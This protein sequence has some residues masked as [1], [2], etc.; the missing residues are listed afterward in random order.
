MVADYESMIAPE[1][2]YAV[3]L[4]KKGDLRW[5]SSD[6]ERKTQPARGF[7]QR[8]TDFFWRLIPVEGQL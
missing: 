4:N 1:N 6:G 8:C 3:T 2:A 7:G 5:N